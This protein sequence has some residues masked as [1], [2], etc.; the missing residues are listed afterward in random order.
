MPTLYLLINQKWL[1]GAP[2]DENGIKLGGYA[3]AE[4]KSTI[5]WNDLRNSNLNLIE[6]RGRIRL[7]DEEIDEPDEDE[8]TDADEPNEGDEEKKD[9]KKYGLPREIILRDG[10]VIETKKGTVPRRAHFTCASCGREG[11]TLESVRFTGHTAPVAAYALQC[12]CAQCEI[13]SYAYGG[14]YFKY[15]D[16]YDIHRIKATETEWENRS[17]VDFDGILAPT[18]MLGCLHDA[19]Q[20]RCQ[21][22]LGLHSLVEDV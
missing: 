15:P 13:E 5:H 11:N 21:R 22:R 6:V 2:G 9:R 4:A 8:T 7:A 1:T 19:G 12:H 3:G 17:E 20:R 16:S 18:G 10:A 14:R